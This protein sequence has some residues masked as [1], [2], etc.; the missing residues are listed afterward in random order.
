MRT[1]AYFNMRN[2]R[3]L[4][5][6]AKIRAIEVEHGNCT[7]AATGDD[8]RVHNTNETGHR[9]WIPGEVLLEAKPTRKP[10]NQACTAPSL[11]VA[12]G[13]TRHF[14]AVTIARV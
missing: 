6:W 1:F 5:R 13:E 10:K 14:L 7:D 8:E 2:V 3:S 4:G 12:T 11:G 9:R